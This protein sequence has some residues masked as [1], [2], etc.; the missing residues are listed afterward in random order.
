LLSQCEYALNSTYQ[1]AVKNIPFNIIYGFIPTL[2]IDNTLSSLTV[3]AVGNTVA[4]R[5]KV[6]L[7]VKKA[8][9]D[10]QRS[11]EV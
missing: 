3:P 7:Q 11:M 1:V 9:A 8:L 10:S 5:L 2:P 4:A 6:Q